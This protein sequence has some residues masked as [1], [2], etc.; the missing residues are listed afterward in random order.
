M[1]KFRQH[2]TEKAIYRILG[3]TGAFLK[4]ISVFV[5]I[6]SAILFIGAV[7]SENGVIYL[8]GGLGSLIG[9]LVLFSFGN[10]LIKIQVNMLEEVEEDSI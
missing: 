2:A 10:S 3:L 5:F 7:S 8:G 9:G 4:G 1:A 6:Y